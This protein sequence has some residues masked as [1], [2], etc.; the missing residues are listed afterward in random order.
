ML[1]VYI[2]IRMHKNV[3]LI[4]IIRIP[5]NIKDVFYQCQ[6]LAKK[7][8]FIGDFSLNNTFAMR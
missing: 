7:G 6:L 3:H 4:T 2:S 8:L 5:Q 1:I